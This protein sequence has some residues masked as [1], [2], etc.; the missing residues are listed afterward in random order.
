V[1]QELKG[2]YREVVGV[3]DVLS[4]NTDFLDVR[5]LIMGL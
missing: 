5:S 2:E 4:K 1:W 3:A